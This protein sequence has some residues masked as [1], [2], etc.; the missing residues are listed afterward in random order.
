M[1]LD[2]LAAAFAL[3]GVYFLG[4][5]NKYGFIICMVSCAIWIIVAL[6]IGVYGLLLEVIPL[7]LLNI[8]NFNKWRQKEINNE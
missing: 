5:K 7:F 6:S 4:N 8:Y 2:W 1:F 3:V